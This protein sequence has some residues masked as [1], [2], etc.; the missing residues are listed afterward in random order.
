M[1]MCRVA[2]V[3]LTIAELDPTMRRL[4]TSTAFRISTP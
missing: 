2:L 4:S 3:P 1:T